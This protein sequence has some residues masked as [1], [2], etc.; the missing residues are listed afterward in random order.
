VEEKLGKL[1]D[2]Q[3]KWK[4]SEARG[5][6]ENPI[7]HEETLSKIW[8][9]AMATSVAFVAAECRSPEEAR[10]IAKHP[11]WPDHWRAVLQSYQGVF[12]V[13]DYASDQVSQ[14]PD[15]HALGGYLEYIEWARFERDMERDGH[16][17]V[18][19]A[20][21]ERHVFSSF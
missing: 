17:V 21:G 12:D 19:I 6:D 9:V 4:V 14:R 1:P 15:R 5:F 8:R 13:G 3:H 20:D 10:D 18:V 16:I 7:R 2:C 11:G